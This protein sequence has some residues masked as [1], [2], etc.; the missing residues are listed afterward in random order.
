[1][2]KSLSSTER[3]YKIHNKELLSVIQGLEEWRHIMEGTKHTIE[4]L[5]DHWN[6]MYFQA[7]QN[8]NHGKAQWSLFQSRFDFSL[9]HRPGQH[10]S[11]LDALSCQMDHLTEEEDN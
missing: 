6:L 7:S 4:I 1:M 5:N 9:S 10:S 3:N 2:S 11:K 8:L